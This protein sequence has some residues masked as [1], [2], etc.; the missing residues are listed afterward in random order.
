MQS[1]E[2]ALEVSAALQEG[3]EVVCDRI[4][5]KLM[6]SFDYACF[7]KQTAVKVASKEGDGDIGCGPFQK[8]T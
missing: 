8:R 6:L 5:R 1:S 2:E 4:L 7:V 3:I